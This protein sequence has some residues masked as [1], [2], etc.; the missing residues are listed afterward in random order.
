MDSR[1]GVLGIM[2]V[3]WT[4]LGVLS[5]SLERFVELALVAEL[6]IEACLKSVDR[7]GLSKVDRAVMVARAVGALLIVAVG[8]VNPLDSTFPTAFEGE[9]IGLASGNLD[10]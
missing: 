4:A 2:D 1:D 7:L 5:K 3:L 8:F 10:K 9:L 6:W